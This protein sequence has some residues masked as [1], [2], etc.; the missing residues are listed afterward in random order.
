MICFVS[1]FR[2]VGNSGVGRKLEVRLNQLGD[3]I[4]DGVVQV[5]GRV[6][7]PCQGLDSES[8]DGV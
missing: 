7:R 8:N 6:E 2:D 1:L 5:I 3:G 4:G